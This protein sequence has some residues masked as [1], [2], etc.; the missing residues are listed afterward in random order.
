MIFVSI[1]TLISLSTLSATLDDVKLPDTVQVA[2]KSLVLNG[3]GIRRATFLNIHVYVGGFYMEKKSKHFNKFLND[4]SPKHI[5]MNF[6]R[7]VSASKLAGGWKDAFE[8]SLS[9]KEK[10]SLKKEIDKL[11]SSM[12]D[13]KEGDQIKYT[14]LKDGVETESKGVKLAKISSKE[15]SRAMLSVW[16][17]NAG[18]E[19]LKKGLLGL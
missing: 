15:F 9:D 13:V 10:K 6:V 11:L 18:D 17:I 16:F 1:L 12:P 7:S 14:F 5:I 4:D 19:G 8:D 2:G 3:M